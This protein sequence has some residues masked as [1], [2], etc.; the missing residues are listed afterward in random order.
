MLKGEVQLHIY[1]TSAH[2]TVML[3]HEDTPG[4]ADEVLRWLDSHVGAAPRD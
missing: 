1:D 2:G 3:S 4:L